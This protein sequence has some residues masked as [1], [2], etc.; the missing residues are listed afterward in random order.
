MGILA[1][2]VPEKIAGQAL[3]QLLKRRSLTPQYFQDTDAL[4]EDVR[5][6]LVDLIVLDLSAIPRVSKDLAAILA[7]LHDIPVI[8][9]T[10]YATTEK[11]TANFRD[12][13]YHLLE[14]PIR[15]DEMVRLIQT[16]RPK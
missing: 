12:N 6:G 16:L 11:E 13:G 15:L 2:Y 4:L 5:F 10:P 14:K 7:I 1:V 3:C 9:V 8:M